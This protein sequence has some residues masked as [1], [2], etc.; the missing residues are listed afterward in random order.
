MPGSP[1]KSHGRKQPGPSGHD[2]KGG[3]PAY[4][5]VSEEHAEQL[6]Q[7]AFSGRGVDEMLDEELARFHIKPGLQKQHCFLMFSYGFLSWIDASG[8]HRAFFLGWAVECALLLRI[9]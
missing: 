2:S 6:F 1:S 8:L 4:S 5:T 9:I 7:A 3:R